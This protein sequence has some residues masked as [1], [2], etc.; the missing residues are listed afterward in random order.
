CGAD[1]GKDDV[2]RRR[3]P[4]VPPPRTDVRDEATRPAP[5]AHEDTT[6]PTGP[7]RRANRRAA[8]ASCR[9]FA[10]PPTCVLEPDHRA[11]TAPNGEAPVAGPRRRSGV[12][13]AA[14]HQ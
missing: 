10:R 7:G 11:R 13:I 5:M 1:A 4:A 3:P 12:R 6:V 2:S 8:A 9:E 14:L